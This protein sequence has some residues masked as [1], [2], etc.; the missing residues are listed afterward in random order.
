MGVSPAERDSKREQAFAL[1]MQ[2][3]PYR[4]IARQLGINKSTVVEYVRQERARRSRDRDAEDAVR[5]VVAVLRASLEYLFRQLRETEGTG[6]HAAYAKARL[7]AEIR[8]T[9]RDLALVYGVELPKIDGEEITLDRMLR[10]VQ[11]ELDATPIGYP[12]VSEQAILDRY[13]VEQDR[14]LVDLGVIAPGAA[15][16]RT[17]SDAEDYGGHYHLSDWPI[18]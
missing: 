11:D 15:M 3:V 8:R 4:E 9:A 7:G 1:A 14:H 5:D 17:A 10:R 6:P 18:D 12:D 13:A 2:R 16:R